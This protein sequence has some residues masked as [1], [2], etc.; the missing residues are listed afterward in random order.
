MDLRVLDVVETELS[1]AGPAAVICKTLSAV[2]QLVSCNYAKYFVNNCIIVN[3]SSTFESEDAKKKC[4][5]T[6]YS[7]IEDNIK[8][9]ELEKSAF[10]QYL[11]NFELR[12]FYGPA[13]LKLPKWQPEVERYDWDDLYINAEQTAKELGLS[14]G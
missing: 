13:L 7:F 9:P 2:G 11:E 4:R 1:G 12:P 14:S 8:V 5:E 6:C 10:D 3:A